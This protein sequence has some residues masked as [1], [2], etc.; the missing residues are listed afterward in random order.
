MDR[1]FEGLV[2]R[3]NELERQ[4]RRWRRAGLVILIG[5]ASLLVMGQAR[6]P[7]VVEADEVV[8]HKLTILDDHGSP[9]AVLDVTK[10][11]AGLVL[12]D[13]AGNPNGILVA[14][15]DGARLILSNAA[16]KASGALGVTKEGADLILHDAAGKASAALFITKEGP[17]LELNDAAGKS[18]AYLDLSQHGPF[19]AI[20]DAEGF[21]TIVGTADL[22]GVRTGE[23]RKRS[24]ASAVMFN[25]EGSVIWS[26]P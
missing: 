26:A 13:A 20:R 16:G 12:R 22:V 15:K 8:A 14:T 2:D 25:K 10:A 7:R 19:L 17:S 11:G 6:T 21:K 18:E 4:N 24:A 9:V 3:L 5:L 1:D 23:Q